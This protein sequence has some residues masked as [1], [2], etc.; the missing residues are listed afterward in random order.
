MDG[1][2]GQVTV[3]E[4]NFDVSN[5]L[6]TH[7]TLETA[8]RRNASPGVDGFRIDILDAAGGVIATTT[9]MPT[10]FLMRTVV[11]PVTFP[12]AGTYTLRLTEVGND[13]SLGAII[14]NV[15]L[16]TCFVS[17]TLIA[18]AAGPRAVERL[19][20][21]DILPTG[22]G[23]RPVL[24][25]G[26]SRVSECEQAN[27]P[28]RRPVLIEAGA[29]GEGL[30]RRDLCVSRQHRVALTH[31][32]LTGLG[33]PPAILVPAATLT[34]LPGIRVLPPA[35]AVVYHHLLLDRH[36]VIESEGARTESLL[37][38]PMCRAALDPRHLRQI[39]ARAPGALDRASPL[40]RPALPV[41][42]GRAARD[43]ARALWSRHASLVG[44]ADADRRVTAEVS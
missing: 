44:P 14:D 5:P 32:G 43:L 20:P 4:Q 10:E 3:M 11:L 26:G 35:G 38:G 8:M 37:L 24:W 18:T 6:A 16:M 22:T 1:R 9:V 7:L 42:E 17:G 19:R 34:D 25:I 30:P 31:P 21:G 39:L 33:A 36:A 27:L 40:G 2:S 13:D 29:L 41:V 15:T 12:A 23:Q 28:R